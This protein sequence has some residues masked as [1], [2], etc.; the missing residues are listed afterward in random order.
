LRESEF[1]TATLGETIALHERVKQGDVRPVTEAAAAII[2]ELTLGASLAAEL[3]KRLPPGDALHERIATYGVQM[4]EIIGRIGEIT[5]DDADE[6]DPDEP[7][8]DQT[9]GADVDAE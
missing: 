8:A 1:V 6:A 5:V 4:T 2:E 3:A 9:E 7:D